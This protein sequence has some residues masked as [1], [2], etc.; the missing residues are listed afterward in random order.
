MRFLGV[1]SWSAW[2]ISLKI[3]ENQHAFQDCSEARNLCHSLLYAEQSVMVRTHS[4][5]SDGPAEIKWCFKWH[6]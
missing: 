5:Q 4:L 3:R 6:I 2:G 1:W